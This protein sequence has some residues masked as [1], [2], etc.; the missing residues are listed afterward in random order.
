[1]IAYGNNANNQYL[2]VNVNQV[3]SIGVGGTN[4][5]M[6]GIATVPG[7]CSGRVGGGSPTGVE[8]LVPTLRQASDPGFRVD[9]TEDYISSVNLLVT[10]S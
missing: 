9:F 2:D 1:M 6:A 8:V 5:T 4:F 3:T 10:R 7:V